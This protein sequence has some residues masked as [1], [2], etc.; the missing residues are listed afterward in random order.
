MIPTA[1]ILDALQ[2]TIDATG[3]FDRVTRHSSA[4]L[5][6]AL[7]ALRDPAPKLCFIIP[8]TDTW[9]HVLLE[10]R[11]I[12]QSATLKSEVTLLITAHDATHTRS[13][14]DTAYPLKDHLQA[15]LCWDNLSIPNL[16]TLPQTCEPMRIEWDDAPARTAWQLTLEIRQTLTA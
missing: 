5:P 12:P 15:A 9:D 2:S 3:L 4:D 13:G 6:E 7:E 14:S 8:G 1:E 16:L 10:D 11:N